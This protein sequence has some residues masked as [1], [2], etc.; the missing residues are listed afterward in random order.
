MIKALVFDM[1]GV[2]IDSEPIHTQILVQVLKELGKDVDPREFD[3]FIGMRDDEMWGVLKKR[4]MLKE[5]VE[6]LLA[7]H[8][9]YKK[10]RF[11]GNDLE[12]IQGI[13]ELISKAKSMNLKIALATSSHR[14]LAEQILK[15]LKIRHYF[16]ALVTGNDVSNSKPDPEV[17]I[18]AALSLGVEP[19]ECIAIEDSYFGIKASKGAGMKCIAYLNP[20]SGSQDTS[21]ADLTVSSIKDID[22]DKIIELLGR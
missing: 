17:Y 22:L 14:F 7:L 18:K 12:P 8:D 10:K 1:D 9:T 6:Q 15:T 5:T 3:E 4:H 20:N 19:S 13:P 16:D 21:S 2:I 11:F